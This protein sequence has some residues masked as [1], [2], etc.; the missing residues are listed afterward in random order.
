MRRTS[1]DLVRNPYASPQQ[2]RRVQPRGP[3]RRVAAYGG[4][5][6]SVGEAKR[7]CFIQHDL[8]DLSL[9]SWL[10]AAQA[11]VERQIEGKR[12]LM[13]VLYEMPLTCWWEGALA[14]PHPPLQGVTSI[15]YYDTAGTEQTLATTVYLVDNKALS[16]P[17]TVERAPGQ[18]WPAFQ[19]D[20][21]LPITVRYTAG[22][23][24]P[25]TAATTDTLTSTGR[26]FTDQDRGQFYPAG[27][28]GAA[29]PGGLFA[30]RDYWVR[31]ASG[32]TFKVAEVAGGPAV[33]VTS[34]GT[35]LFFFGEVP[36]D[37]RQAILMIV[38]HWYRHREAA[39]TT[40]PQAV[41]LGVQELLNNLTYGSYA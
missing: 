36:E 27:G 7:H 17:G 34:T 13:P 3:V 40:V 11:Y 25:V 2:P 4:L 30:N 26:A 5:A 6:V 18:S 12:Q 32:Q 38:A 19:S 9:T 10:R 39:M 16:L 28:T 29:L 24:A 37:V 14:L 35:G 15:K 31:D 20:R 8:D 21:R 1:P 41:A 22:Y 33:D 23:L